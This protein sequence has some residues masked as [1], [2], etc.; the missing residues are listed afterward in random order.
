MEQS[1]KKSHQELLKALH[2]TYC[3]KNEKYGNSFSTTVASWGFVAAGVRIEDKFNRMKQ[4]MMSGNLA[5]NGT[6]ERLRDTL[7]DMAN[8]CIMTVMELDGQGTAADK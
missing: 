5:D 7:L 2:E 1:Q 3:E 4:L 6:D 8:Y